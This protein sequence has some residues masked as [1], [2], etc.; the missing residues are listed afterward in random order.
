MIEQE[1]DPLLRHTFK[2]KKFLCWDLETEHLN[3]YKN[4]PWEVG[5][6]LYHGDSLE[7]EE[8]IYINWDLVNDPLEITN[9]AAKLTKYEDWYDPKTGRNMRGK[10]HLV[11]EKGIRPDEACKIIIDY[12]CKDDVYSIGSNLLGFDS[13]VFNFLRRYSNQGVDYSFVNNVYDTVPLTKAA[14]LNLSPPNYQKKNFSWQMK[15]HANKKR[16]RSGIK[17]ACNHFG[18]E[19]KENAHHDAI[20]DNHMTWEIFKKILFEMEVR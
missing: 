15:I 1:G 2:N 19:Y 14:I 8:V 3:L 13:H 12:L 5:L 18:I 6:S 7:K 9:I 4:K 17:G 20:A 10:K 16:V 11:K